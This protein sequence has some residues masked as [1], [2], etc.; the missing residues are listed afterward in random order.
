MKKDRHIQKLIDCLIIVSFK[1]GNLVPA[2][3]KKNTVALR[4]LSSRKA[5]Y[6]LNLYLK[7]LKRE[8]KKTTMEI[9]S[10]SPLSL[11]QKAKV[12]NRFKKE[13]Q[14][15]SIKEINTPSLIGGLQVKIGDW[16]FDAS[17]MNK[18]SQVKEAIN[19]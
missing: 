5:I 4:Q 1:N 6:A 2:V 7:G 8:L 10:A 11:T 14:I 17:V 12:Q 19:G 3:V 13:F 15:K 18:I 9:S 16:M